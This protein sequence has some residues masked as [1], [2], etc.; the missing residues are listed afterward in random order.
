MDAG[1]LDQ[2]VAIQAFSE[3]GR[4]AQG[5]RVGTWSTVATEWMEVAPVSGRELIALRAAGSEMTVRFRMRYRD[6]LTALHRFVWRGQTFD[7][8]PPVGRPR[9]G[10]LEVMG[11]VADPTT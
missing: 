6:G 2:Q 4:G 11:R 1:R 3:T 5:S 9:S 10:W 8:E 7:I